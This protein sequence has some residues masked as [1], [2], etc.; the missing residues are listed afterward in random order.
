MGDDV[1]FFEVGYRFRNPAINTWD[2]QILDALWHIY[3]LV[4]TTLTLLRPFARHLVWNMTIHCSFSHHDTHR[5]VYLHQ[6]ILYNQWGYISYAYKHLGCI[7]K[8]SNG[9]TKW[10][11]M[12]TK[13]WDRPPK[14]NMT[15]EQTTFWR[16][17]PYYSP[18]KNDDFSL[19]C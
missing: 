3:W 14:T 6:A 8:S 7:E 19:P 16:C 12:R 9:I 5:P 18:I 15:M 13:K 1:F 10:D 17:I 11:K 2:D 4:R